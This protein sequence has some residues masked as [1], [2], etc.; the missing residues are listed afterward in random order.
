MLHGYTVLMEEIPSRHII[1]CAGISLL[2]GENMSWYT[3]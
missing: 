3:I 1:F 2:R